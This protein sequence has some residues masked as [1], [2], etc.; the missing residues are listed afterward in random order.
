MLNPTTTPRTLDTICTATAPDAVQTLRTHRD[1]TQAGYPNSVLGNQNSPTSATKTQVTGLPTVKSPRRGTSQVRR[2]GFQ[3]VHAIRLVGLPAG[4][5][6]PPLPGA[7]S[8]TSLAVSTQP[9]TTRAGRFRRPPTQGLHPESEPDREPS[10]VARHPSLPYAPAATSRIAE[11]WNIREAG[12]SGVAVQQHV[13][14]AA[15]LGKRRAPASALG[16]RA[17]CDIPAT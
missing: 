15:A 14:T 2:V 1:A 11:G 6:G 7:G 4:R 8:V 5:A 16:N 17:E 12:P 10:Q 3:H 9:L 13:A